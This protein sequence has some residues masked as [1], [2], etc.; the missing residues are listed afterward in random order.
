LL[1]R[2]AKGALLVK[3]PRSLAIAVNDSSS[4]RNGK[5]RRAFRQGA[6]SAISVELASGHPLI[7]F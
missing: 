7:T 1:W 6:S 5:G 4:P 2:K 3:M